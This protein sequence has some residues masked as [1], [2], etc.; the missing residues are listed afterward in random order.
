MSTYLAEGY[1]NSQYIRL[2]VRPFVNIWYSVICPRNFSLKSLKASYAVKI[3]ISQMCNVEV[4]Q[5][6]RYFFSE[7]TAETK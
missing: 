5:F 2:S 1:W 7:T 6:D 3:Y 4:S